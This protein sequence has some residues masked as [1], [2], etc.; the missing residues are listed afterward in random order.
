[1]TLKYYL[2]VSV[3][4]V[5]MLF[6]QIPRAFLS[7]VEG[8]LTVNLGVVSTT[9]KQGSD[10]E[11]TY[12]KLGAVIRYLEKHE[13]IGTVDEPKDYFRG[14]MLMKWGPYGF[15]PEKSPLVYF[16]GTSSET[17]VGLG[18]SS[19]HVVGAGG[20]S[21]AHSHSVTPLLVDK[22]YQGLELPVSAEGKT[23]L[24]QQQELIA[25]AVYLATD[26]MTGEAQD[27][28]FFA[29]RLAFFPKGQHQAGPVEMNI[30][31]GTPL[32]VSASA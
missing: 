27:V 20:S 32:Y 12:A 17:I 8:E 4:K 5:D 19:H 15:D 10:P 28:E 23:S 29:R 26:Q 22:L 14:Q 31:L 1:M 30:L 24:S 13:P 21:S 7:G 3:S 11:T 9:I 2:Y 25:T 18:G 16:G 6:A